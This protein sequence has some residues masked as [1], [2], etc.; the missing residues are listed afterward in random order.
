MVESN[1]KQIPKDL[2]QWFQNPNNYIVNDYASFEA[3]LA[4]TK[5]SLKAYMSDHSKEWEQDDFVTFQVKGM[6]DGFAL[7]FL[8]NG[9][10]DIC[11]VH[12]NSKLKGISDAMLTFAKSQGGNMLDNY[13]GGLSKI[14]DRN[15]FDVYD[16]LEWDD[17][18]KPNEWDDSRGTPNVELRKL[19]KHHEKYANDLGYKNHFD[20]KMKKRFPPKM[21]DDNITESIIFAIKDLLLKEL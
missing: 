2:F 11:N 3:S 12:N 15:K 19:K 4:K 6:D 14:Y 18:Y 20:K 5:P 13:A 8:G 16:E 9:E 1:E 7:H 10:V 21:E 17:K